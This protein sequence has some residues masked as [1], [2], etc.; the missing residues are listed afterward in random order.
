MLEHAGISGIFL[1]SFQCSRC[2]T[3]PNLP[4]FPSKVLGVPLPQH[5]IEIPRSSS[6]CGLLKT[7]DA[8]W[9]PEPCALAEC[10]ELDMSLIASRGNAR[11]ARELKDLTPTPPLLKEV[12]AETS[13]DNGKFTI[14]REFTPYQMML[15]S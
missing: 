9:L 2:T 8:M 14:A 10:I 4:S 1:R 5:C 13:V 11:W 6:V 15:C 7:R 3:Y 12:C